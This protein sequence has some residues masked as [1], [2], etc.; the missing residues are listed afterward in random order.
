MSTSDIKELAG[1]AEAQRRQRR[2]QLAKD[3]EVMSINALEELLAQDCLDAELKR[4]VTE[5]LLVAKR[6]AKRDPDGQDIALSS[7]ERQ[8]LPVAVLVF[9]SLTWMIPR[10]GASGGVLD[11]FQALAFIACGVGW[12][13]ARAWLVE[14]IL[15]VKRAQAMLG[16][17][18]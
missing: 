13:K 10:L 11:T 1:A 9:G 5:R 4:A 3:F 12:W 15:D 14:A 17:V 18:D 6:E 7:R 8:A 2:E 16:K